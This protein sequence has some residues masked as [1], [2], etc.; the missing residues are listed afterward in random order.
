M[1][2]APLPRRDWP[3]RPEPEGLRRFRSSPQA[4]PK[5]FDLTAYQ[6]RPNPALAQRLDLDDAL[7]GTGFCACP[8]GFRMPT[9]GP[10]SVL[11][12]HPPMW[13]GPRVRV[14]HC[15][16]RRQTRRCPSTSERCEQ[17]NEDTARKPDQFSNSQNHDETTSKSNRRQLPPPIQRKTK[18]T[19]E[20]K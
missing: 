6:R 19:A 15:R 18:E 11:R 3:V 12:P 20:N 8:H 16:C 4:P 14:F 5:G 13:S 1:N 10:V 17:Q 7:F 2:F 9:F